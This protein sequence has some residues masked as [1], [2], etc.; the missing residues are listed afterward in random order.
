[1][2]AAPPELQDIL[3]AKDAVAREEAWSRFVKRFS[4]L[5]LHTARAAAPEHDRAM[6]AYAYVLEELHR[7]DGQRLRHYI[8]DPRAQF[9]TWLVIVARRLCVDFLRQRYG[10]VQSAPDSAKANQ[11]VR[12]RLV[13]LIA[14]EIG[15]INPIADPRLGPDEELARHELASIL[16]SCLA[17]LTPA[18]RLLLAMRFENELPVREIAR[19]LHYP[20]PFHVYRTL[21]ALLGDLRRALRERGVREADP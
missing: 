16:Q 6:D 21:N 20:T 3:Q 19:I 13:D 9:T 7:E 4:P 8:E 1:M 10:R 17:R 14:E 18:H 15:D 2:A 11:A 5:L 12:R